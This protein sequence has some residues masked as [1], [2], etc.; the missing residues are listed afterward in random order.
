MP[1]EIDKIILNDVEYDIAG[2]GGGGTGGGGTS[3]YND[4]T[5]KPKINN[6][7]LIGNK[8]LD[9]LGIQPKILEVKEEEGI[10][11]AELPIE[12]PKVVAQEVV[13]QSL[14]G[15]ISWSNVTGK[16]TLDATASVNN[17]TGTPSVTVSKSETASAVTFDFKFKNLKGAKGDKGDDGTGVSIKGS[18]NDE[19]ELPDSGVSGDAYLDATG[20]LWVYV[21]TGGD[22]TN[23]KFKNAGNIKGPKGDPGATVPLNAF[24]TMYVDAEGNLYART[25]DGAEKPPLRYDSATGNLYWE[26]Q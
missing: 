5:N 25:A 18:V 23:G 21:G 13:A 17:A 11:E 10:A 8:T 2:S 4:L 20:N 15:N 9:D 16:P 14:N 6:V 24:F 7:E 19:T 12:A 3:D 1:N 26:A 22:S